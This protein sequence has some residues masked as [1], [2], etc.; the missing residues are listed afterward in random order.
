[1]WSL[2]LASKYM[3]TACKFQ[4]K[5]GGAQKNPFAPCH[6]MFD[7][8]RKTVHLWQQACTV[9]CLWLPWTFLFHL[10]ITSLNLLFHLMCIKFSLRP[11]SVMLALLIF[12]FFIANLI[13][14]LW[15]IVSETHYLAQLGHKL[16]VAGIPRMQMNRLKI[17]IIS[18]FYFHLSLSMLTYRCHLLSAMGLMCRVLSQETG[19]GTPSL[20]KFPFLL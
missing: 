9:A 4:L 10:L 19:P 18:N 15:V 5:Q 16:S 13:F 2:I 17:Y 7:W 12:F 3:L 14:I 20:V 1:M 8:S 6:K 11:L